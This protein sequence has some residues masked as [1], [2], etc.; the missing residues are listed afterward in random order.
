MA[1]LRQSIPEVDG[2]SRGSRTIAAG[3]D[4]I[5]GRGEIARKLSSIIMK[6]ED[7]GGKIPRS[8]AAER[9]EE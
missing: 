5:R 7:A 6:E 4:R 8:G 1:A 9:G 3:H 2:T